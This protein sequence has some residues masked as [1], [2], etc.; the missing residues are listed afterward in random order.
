MEASPRAVRPTD[1][2]NKADPQFE[3]NPNFFAD[4]IF[5]N[6]SAESTLVTDTKAV[7]T[8]ADERQWDSTADTQFEV[9][10]TFF[11]DSIL[12]KFGA[13]STFV[14]ADMKA[15]STFADVAADERQWEEKDE[16]RCE[17]FGNSELSNQRLRTMQLEYRSEEQQ[18]DLQIKAA[19]TGFILVATS[20]KAYYTQ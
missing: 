18:L 4:S 13:N 5:T 16:E 1:N 6:F 17:I 7:S 14:T 19:Q 11:A 20:T 12:T 15:V 9:G 3:V 2:D 10:P 8:F